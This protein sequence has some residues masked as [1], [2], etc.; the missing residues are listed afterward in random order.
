MQH[1]LLDTMAR[2]VEQGCEER[3]AAARAEADAIVSEA[4][5]RADKRYAEG[6]ERAQREVDR[7]ARRA[8]ELAAVQAKQQSH[9]MQQAVA[10]EILHS[11]DAELDRIAE[12]PEFPGILDA[13]LR[14]LMA[15]APENAEVLAPP[16]HVERC[17]QWLA[18][19][20]HAGVPVVPHAALHDGVAIQDAQRT[21]RV[22]N[23]L[24]SRFHKLENEARKIC[25]RLLFGKGA[26]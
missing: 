12:G 22:T 11:V 21:F 24:S 16:A 7:L 14:E 18:A 25:L 10:D 2:Q 1:V 15:T 9:S 23:S 5:E 17:R 20:G 3:L 19:N 8:R 6:I 26:E 4:R 13:L